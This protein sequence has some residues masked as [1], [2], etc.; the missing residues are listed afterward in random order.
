[1]LLARVKNKPSAIGSKESILRVHLKP[2][3]GGKKLDQIGYAEIQ[4][5]AAQKTL[6]KEKKPGLSKKTVNNHLTMLRRILVVAKKRGLLDVVPE[7][8]WLRA[9]KPG[10]DF[11]AGRA[12]R[13][14][15]GGCGSEEGASTGSQC[16]VHLSG[17][18]NAVTKSSSSCWRRLKSVRSSLSSFSRAHVA[19]GGQDVWQRWGNI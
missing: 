10:F 2:A 1:M 7:I 18:V 9:P 19:P 5:Y 13:A 4:D 14:A 11:L 15:V 17:F 3:F 8:E 16:R 6:A 12:S